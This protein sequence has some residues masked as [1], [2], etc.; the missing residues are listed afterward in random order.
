MEKGIDFTE[1]SDTELMEI[2]GGAFPVLLIKMFGP[3]IAGLIAFWDGL[4]D[5]YAQTTQP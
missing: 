3:N 4:K 1:L 5:G 2:S